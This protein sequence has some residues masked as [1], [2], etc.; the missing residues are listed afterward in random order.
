MA[1]AKRYGGI[2]TGPALFGF[3]A[4]AH[5]AEEEVPVADLVLLT[6]RMLLH[7]ESRVHL[8]RLDGGKGYLTRAELREYLAEIAGLTPPAADPWD[9]PPGELSED[10]YVA[11]VCAVFHVFFD[12]S[13]R[14]HVATESLLQSTLLLDMVTVRL[15]RRQAAERKQLDPGRTCHRK[16]SHDSAGS[17]REA[18]S[19][20]DAVGSLVGVDY[21]KQVRDEFSKICSFSRGDCGRSE[22]SAA[23]VYEGLPHLSRNFVSRVLDGYPG[24]CMGYGDFCEFFIL[25]KAPG[26]DEALPLCWRVL[27]VAGAGRVTVSDLLDFLRGNQWDLPEPALNSIAFEAFD[28]VAHAGENSDK[29]FFTVADLKKVGDTLRMSV[30]GLIFSRDPPTIEDEE[31]PSPPDFCLVEDP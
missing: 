20:L 13:R 4:H 18:D 2:P 28:T 27:D 19:V 22:V 24:G 3:L 8:S 29:G 11:G 25:S 5:D 10:A 9:S 23:Q 30:F 26:S 16:Q 21:Q 14:N 12:S 31:P 17:S 1:E 15:S 7:Y 6:H